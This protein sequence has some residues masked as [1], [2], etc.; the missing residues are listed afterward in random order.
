MLPAFY[1]A[2]NHHQ[3]FETLH[4]Y[5]PYIII[6]DLPKIEHLKR[7]YPGLYTSTPSPY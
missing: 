2:E 5:Y 6:N 1:A 3:N 4:P 7:D